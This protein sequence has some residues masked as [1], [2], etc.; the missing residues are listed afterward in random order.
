MEHKLREKGEICWQLQ[1]IRILFVE[2]GEPLD[3][4]NE[5]PVDP[6]QRLIGRF[7]RK[8]VRSSPTRQP[9]HHNTGRLVVKA[10]GYRRPLRLQIA[11]RP[12][13]CRHPNSLMPVGVLVVRDELEHRPGALLHGTP[14]LGTHFEQNGDCIPVV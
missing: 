2:V 6:T 10:V 11:P 7:A 12:A 1:R 8:V 4:A 3:K 5:A 9:T 13:R 14:V